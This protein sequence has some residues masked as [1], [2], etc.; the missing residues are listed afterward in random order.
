MSP[1]R[2]AFKGLYVCMGALEPD[3]VSSRFRLDRAPVAIA[4]APQPLPTV[5]RTP[6]SSA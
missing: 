4:T 6:T 2:N 5:V 3:V 1:M